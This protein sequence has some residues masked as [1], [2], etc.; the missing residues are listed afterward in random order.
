MKWHWKLRSRNWV[1]PDRPIVPPQSLSGTW[2]G[3][4]DP[5]GTVPLTLIGK[6]SKFSSC[7]PA[8]NAWFQGRIEKQQFSGQLIFSNGDRV[9]FRSQLEAKAVK[10]GRS[11]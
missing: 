5:N 11:H 10:E 4:P 6:I 1:L 9:P 8:Q 2:S 7:Y 3:V